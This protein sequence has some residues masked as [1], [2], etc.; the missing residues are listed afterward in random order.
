MTVPID[1]N[2]RYEPIGSICLS[3]RNRTAVRNPVRLVPK[4]GKN[5]MK[6]SRTLGT[7]LHHKQHWL[8]GDFSHPHSRTYVPD[9]IYG[10]AVRYGA[11]AGVPS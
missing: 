2:S 9:S 11:F 4:M 6:S 8:G 3:H 10:T 1:E 5:I 7:I